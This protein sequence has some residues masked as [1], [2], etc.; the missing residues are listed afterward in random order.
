MDYIFQKEFWKA[1]A[2]R[3]IRTL[4]QTFLAAGA[5]ARVME[6]LDWHFIISAS[7]L[8]SLLSIATSIIG[9]GLPEAKE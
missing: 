8:A 7:I 1:A 9:G 2:T 3:A 5:T 4:A 6:D